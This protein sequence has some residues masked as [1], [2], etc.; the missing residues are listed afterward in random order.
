MK[1]AVLFDFDGVFNLFPTT[2]EVIN[3]TGPDAFVQ[4][5]VFVLGSFFTI[6]L[7]PSTVAFFNS[8]VDNPDVDVFWLT[9]WREHTEKFDG[10]YKFGFKPA[11]W[12]P[13][14]NTGYQGWGKLDAVVDFVAQDGVYYERI[15]WVDD[16]HNSAANM[17]RDFLDLHP[18]VLA[19]SPDV[20]QGMSAED[21][22]TIKDF[23][24][25]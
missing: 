8:L 18:Q 21:I 25:V 22:Q 9:T 6:T 2:D 10:E 23:I 15:A 20:N 3:N 7:R 16:D 13:W 24:R 17:T 14:N 12:L 1:T 19:L 11:P 4:K 5:K